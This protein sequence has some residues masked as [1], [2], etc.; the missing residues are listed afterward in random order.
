MSWLVVIGMLVFSETEQPVV[1][2]FDGLTAPEAP[3]TPETDAEAP[4]DAATTRPVMPDIDSEAL[5]VTVNRVR[6][7]Q[8]RQEAVVNPPVRRAPG[9]SPARGNPARVSEAAL[10]AL[11]LDAVGR[12]AALESLPLRDAAPA[13]P[14]ALPADPL[15]DSEALPDEAVDSLLAL[16][17]E[18]LR[19][20]LFA[21]MITGS[22]AYVEALGA[23]AH[24]FQA[25]LEEPL[26]KAVEDPTLSSAN[27]AAAAFLLGRM[28][29]RAAV[30]ALKPLVRSTDP[31][32]AEAA[33]TALWRM[34][35]ITLFGTWTE[36]LQHP[37]L[38]MRAIALQ[39]LAQYR[40][41]AAADQ[42]LGVAS[43]G[44]GTPFGLQT[45]ATDLLAEQPPELSVPRL[46]AVMRRNFS[47]RNRAWRYLMAI[48]GETMP[49]I[50]SQW[51][52]WYTAMTTPPQPPPLLPAG[53][54]HTPP[55][56][57][58]LGEI[59]FVPPPLR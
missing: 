34:N 15:T 54:G 25:K 10:D 59:D 13:P 12:R 11:A 30:P 58:L 46:I 55:P 7:L 20:Q 23:S 17:A 45:L 5:L 26:I 6:A 19:D 33:G 9:R 48:T 18:K 14:Y 41:G 24:H 8:A 43:G 38:P 42:L 21:G 36:L 1:L 44:I 32:I 27:R 2:R 40:T 4:A 37:H 3:E 50:P 16:P 56:T 49:E 47:L 57:D 39:G 29:A 31:G 51:S 35:D 52:E 22:P 28:G 53:P